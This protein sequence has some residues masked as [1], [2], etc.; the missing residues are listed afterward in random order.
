MED[1]KDA[2]FGPE[3]LGAIGDSFD[4]ALE[5]LR[6]AG[7]DLGTSSAEDLAAMMLKLG[8]NGLTG[9]ELIRAAVRLILGG[10]GE[11]GEE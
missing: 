11:R 2:T 6:Q 3:Q 8:A 9:E 4:Q 10:R 1:R 5:R 7:H